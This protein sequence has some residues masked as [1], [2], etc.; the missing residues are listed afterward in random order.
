MK[1]DNPASARWYAGISRYQWM[2][3]VVASLGWVF[4]VFEGQ[5]FVASMNEALPALL[6]EGAA[7]DD[8]PYYRDLTFAAFL[9]GGAVGGVFFGRLSDR[10]G[11]TRVMAWTILTYSVA[12]CLS[13]LSQTWWHLACFRFLVALGVGG[14]WAVAA[15]LVAETFPRR[16]RA[17]SLAIFH[18]SSVLGTLLAVLAGA[19]LVAGNAQGWR[20]A[21]AVGAVPALLVLWVRRSLHDPPRTTAP[22][23]TDRPRLLSGPYRKNALIGIGLATV[24]LATFWGTHIYGKDRLRDLVEARQL[25]D[26]PPAERRTHRQQLA[27]T[28]KRWEMTGMLLTTLGGGLGLVSFGPL[29]ERLGRRGAFLLFH[30][31]GLAA[32]LVLFQ[33]LSGV[34]SV[35]AFLPAFGFLTLGMHAGYAVYFPELFPGALRGAG[36]GLC[37]N[38]GRVLAA[39]TLL[40]GGWL[41]AR[42]KMTLE[43]AATLLSLLFLVGIAILAIAPETRG[44]ELPE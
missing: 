12:T 35:L 19:L 34:G 42:E 15:S 2:V 38:L 36:A 8:L 18:A 33:V 32:A 21:F 11:R 16:A 17:W 24:G 27:P 37:F 28:L 43:N 25:Q 7:Q 20:W 14:E 29:A 39:P 1:W 41:Q 4:D 30:L 26:V 23:T 5:V 22:P 10:V 9:L 13:S 31:G 44:K 3:L 40:L 6:P